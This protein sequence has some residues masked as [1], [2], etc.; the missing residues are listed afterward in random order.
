M[1]ISFDYNNI[2][3]S[4][5][6]TVIEKLYHDFSGFKFK[7]EGK[8]IGHIEFGKIS[9]YATLRNSNDNSP[10]AF[11]GHKLGSELQWVVRNTPYKTKTTKTLI[12][13]DTE[14]N[15]YVYEY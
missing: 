12:Y 6:A 15:I 9:L 10:V 8:E 5:V 4:T 7:H 2:E 14:N 11:K 13:E 3:P 1:K